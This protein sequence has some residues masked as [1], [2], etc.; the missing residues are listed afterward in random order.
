[1]MKIFLRLFFPILGAKIN[2]FEVFFKFISYLDFYKIIFD[3]K[4]KKWI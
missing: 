4:R 2:T 1:M 3:D